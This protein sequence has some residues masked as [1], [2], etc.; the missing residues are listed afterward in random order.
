MNV[1]GKLD[2]LVNNISDPFTGTIKINFC[3]M[4][5]KS[6]EVQLLRVETCRM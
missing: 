3:D 4:A 5:I 1:S 6:I 2:S